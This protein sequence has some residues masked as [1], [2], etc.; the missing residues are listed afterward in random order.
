VARIGAVVGG[1]LADERRDEPDVVDPAS[2]GLGR[3]AS[4][5]PVL[6]DAIGINDNK[7]MRVGDRV[8]VGQRLLPRPVPP[9][10]CRFT[11]R[12]T[13]WLTPAGA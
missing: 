2:V 7:P 11:T 3:P 13:G 8:I 6:I 9:P 1:E 4:I 10:P 12:P 5:G